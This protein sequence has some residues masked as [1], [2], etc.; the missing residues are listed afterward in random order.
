M[1]EQEPLTT[2][3]F[4]ERVPMG[5]EDDRTGDK[6]VI[7][8]LDSHVE[9]IVQEYLIQVVPERTGLEI[10]GRISKK[11]GKADCFCRRTLVDG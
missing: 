5:G 9:I 1:P 7:V 6:V 10:R 4:P 3:T 11:V 8:V 2:A